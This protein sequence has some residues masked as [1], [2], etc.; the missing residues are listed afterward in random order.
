MARRAATSTLCARGEER[1]GEAVWIWREIPGGTDRVL[2]VQA[3]VS[4]DKGVA[5]VI[6]GPPN[7]RASISL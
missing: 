1:L 7:L 4:T 3:D 5:D 2:A 6:S